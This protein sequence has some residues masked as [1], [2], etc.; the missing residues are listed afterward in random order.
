MLSCCDLRLKQLCCRQV[1]RVHKCASAVSHPTSTNSAQ[2]QRPYDLRVPLQHAG[3]IAQRAR[4]PARVLPA[5]ARTT[6]SDTSTMRTA[7]VYVSACLPLCP[8]PYLNCGLQTSH[9]PLE[10]SV[11][12]WPQKSYGASVLIRASCK[13][14]PAVKDTT[15]WSCTER[16]DLTPSSRACAACG[17]GCQSCSSAT[18]C[19]TCDDGAYFNNE[20]G[21]C[22]RERMA[23]TLQVPLSPALLAE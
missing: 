9:L 16:N 19:E 7:P 3:L 8:Y 13:L 23:A 10:D 6:E 11:E 20:D 1:R 14:M 21:T 22:L 15:S 4:R 12:C 17:A 5:T 18:V 2:C